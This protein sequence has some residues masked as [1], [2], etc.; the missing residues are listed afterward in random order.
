MKGAYKCRVVDMF[1]LNL[2]LKLETKDSVFVAFE[3]V[4]GGSIEGDRAADN[5][6]SSGMLAL[7]FPTPKL[8]WT[9]QALGISAKRTFLL[10]GSTFTSWMR[11]RQG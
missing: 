1:L 11:F 2:E 8:R 6:N 4:A 7:E 5:W 3:M 10:P 9:V